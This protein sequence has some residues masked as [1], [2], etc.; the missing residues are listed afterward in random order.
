LELVELSELPGPAASLLRRSQADQGGQTRPA[1]RSSGN[2]CEIDPVYGEGLQ[3]VVTGMAAMH[4][5][6][7]RSIGRRRSAGGSATAE[8]RC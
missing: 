3:K 8:S 5:P 4:R 6:L 1:E 7:A 2:A